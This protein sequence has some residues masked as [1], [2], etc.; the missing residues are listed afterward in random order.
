MFA[1]VFVV[2]DAETVF[3]YPWAMSFDVLGVSVFVKALIFVRILI[4]MHG[5]RGHWNGLKSRIFR[6]QKGK[7]TKWRLY[8]SEGIQF[9][10]NQL[11]LSSQEVA[12]KVWNQ[13]IGLMIYLSI[14]D[15]TLDLYLFMNSLGG[16]VIPVMDLY[17]IMQF[18]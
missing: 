6:Q 14:E 8:G 12:S 17:D 2:I 9:D 1:L 4:F 7:K 11:I 16:W 3:L 18:V 10:P 15:D 13:L 5:E